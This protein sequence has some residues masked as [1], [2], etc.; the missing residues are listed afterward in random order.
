[1]VDSEKAEFTIRPRVEVGDP[2]SWLW[3]LAGSL[4]DAFRTATS[5]MAQWLADDY[6]LNSLGK[7]AQVL[8]TSAEFG[9]IK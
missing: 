1:M 6:E 9:V 4:D 7:F 8:G 5:G 3:G 2:Y